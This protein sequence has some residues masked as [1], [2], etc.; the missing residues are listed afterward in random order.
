MVRNNTIPKNHKRFVPNRT[1]FI[2]NLVKEKKVLHIGATDWPYTEEKFNR[3]ALLYVQLGP[4]VKEQLGIDLDADTIKFLEGKKIP[5]SRL[6]QLDMNKA[7]DLNFDSDVI[8]FGETLE[9]LM[10]L[11]IALSN[12][13]KNMNQST[14]LMISVPNAVSFSSFVATLLG[15]ENQHPDHSVAFTYKTLTQLLGKND[16]EVIDFCFSFL[17]PSAWNKLNWKGKVDY[18]IQKLMIKISP[19]FSPTL[20]CVVRLKNG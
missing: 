3:G 13:K 15:R 2:I 18:L 6:I 4:I 14:Q 9:H 5:N 12:I 1:D 19:L 10:N 20:V 8:I 7:T 16:L 11:E 17:E